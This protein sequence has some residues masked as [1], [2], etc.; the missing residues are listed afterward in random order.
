VFER[1]VWSLP[2]TVL[3]GNILN[4]SHKISS[5]KPY[6]KFVSERDVW[7]LPFTVLNGNI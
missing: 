7:P 5:K 6:Y 1:D 4:I 2:F 3:N